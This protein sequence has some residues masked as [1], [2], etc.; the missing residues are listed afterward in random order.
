MNSGSLFCIARVEES[1][2]TEPDVDTRKVRTPY[3]MM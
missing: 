1:C 2:S 3:K